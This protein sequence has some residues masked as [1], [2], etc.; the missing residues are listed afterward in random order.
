MKLQW[1]LAALA[2]FGAVACN[3][4]D[5]AAAPVSSNNTSNNSNNTNGS[6]NS[7]QCAQDSCSAAQTCS[8]EDGAI[9]CACPSGLTGENCDAC[10][11]GFQDKDGDGLCEPD[12]ANAGLDCG[13]NGA[14]SDDG[15][16][17]LCVCNMAY[18][19]A[20]CDACDE[21]YQDQDGDGTCLQ[22]CATSGLDCNSG[23]CLIR[24][25]APTCDCP[26]GSGGDDCSQCGAGYQDND[27]DGVCAPTC[28]T[29]TIDCGANG[30]CSDT[31]GTPACTCAVGYAGEF[32]DE[33][34]PGLQDDDG[35]GVCS[36]ACA[37]GTW[38]DPN[39]QY[40]VAVE[41]PNTTTAVL[42][43][44][45][46]V[47]V[48]IDHA[49]L[50]AAGQSLN[51]GDDVR[52][53]FDDGVTR[54][55]VPR[56][57]ENGW[58]TATTDVA[59]GLEADIPVGGTSK[60]YWI[61]W[62]N[63]NAGAPRQPDIYAVNVDT[64]ESLACG[65]RAGGFMSIQLRQTVPNSTMFEVYAREHTGDG[66]AYADI[67]VVDSVTGASIYTKTYTE[68]GGSCCNPVVDGYGID[69]I[70]IGAQDFTVTLTT[71]EF[72]GTQRYF[73]CSVVG[74][75]NPTLVGTDTRKF[76]FKPTRPEGTTCGR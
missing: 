27:G 57:S 43:K 52:I 73:G 39:F 68:L 64:G 28:A 37:L 55:P 12:C 31:S 13:A 25:G 18:A 71:R 51:S 59:F 15:G 5:D 54:S 9:V 61:Y 50:V 44:G 3:I 76:S 65:Q 36:P 32:C 7:V 60:Q 4:S 29:S 74:T 38:W 17:A 30:V 35:N 67:K 8:V 48:K 14:C 46:I 72:S 1:I 40:R 62:G 47:A 22:D 11:T 58:N 33:C 23:T 21:G 69:Q 19:G 70:N 63:P 56:T 53:V 42:A 41:L 6:N 2:C 24:Q 75:S 26:E 49:A 16:I 66:S 45:T 34:G 10:A 20:N